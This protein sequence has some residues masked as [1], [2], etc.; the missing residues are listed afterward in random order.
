MNLF[1]IVLNYR[2]FKDKI[3]LDIKFSLEYQTLN[4]RLWHAK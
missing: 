2:N 4:G 1:W 3:A